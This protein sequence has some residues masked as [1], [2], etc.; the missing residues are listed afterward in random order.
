MNGVKK[1]RSNNNHIPVRTCTKLRNFSS[2]GHAYVTKKFRLSGDK[3]RIF[4]S[5]N[6]DKDFV[7]LA[8]SFEFNRSITKDIVRVKMT[9]NE[10]NS[11]ARIR[12]IHNESF[13]F[14]VEWLEE[15]PLLTLNQMI[16]KT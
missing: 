16:A 10:P 6:G 9:I 1:R 11:G 5:F 14:V 8:Y 12:K 7:Q 13:K 2:L 15:N 3:A 4:K